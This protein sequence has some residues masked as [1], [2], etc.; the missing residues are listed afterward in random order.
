METH[1]P[2]TAPMPHPATL[3][4]EVPRQL[5]P[6]V[7]RHLRTETEEDQFPTQP[8]LGWSCLNC[9]AAGQLGLAFWSGPSNI[10]WFTPMTIKMVCKG[11]AKPPENLGGLCIKGE[12]H[13]L[14][15]WAPESSIACP[16]KHLVAT[17]CR[18]HHCRKPTQA[19][20][21]PNGGRNTTGFLGFCL[22]VDRGT[23]T[24]RFVG[25]ATIV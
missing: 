8:R 15:T 20:L 16:S 25:G 19:A 11:S 13:E 2:Q 4:K 18:T 14:G 23:E 24:T 21:V 1:N 5:E 6:L 22:E 17:V 12:T 9:W 3:C 10:S 7:L